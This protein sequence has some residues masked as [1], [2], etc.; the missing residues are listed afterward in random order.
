MKVTVKTG[1]L[2]RATAQS[3]AFDLF[4]AESVVVP[5]GAVR[6]V[7]TGVTTEMEGCYAVIKDRSGLA[8]RGLTTRAG[9]IDGDYRQEWGVVLVNESQSPYE[10]N[11]GDRIAQAL[12][13][14]LPAI[15]VV[16][17]GVEQS[18]AV[19]GGGFGSTGG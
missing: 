7:K 11:A 15:E 2:R 1:R 9:V 5:V 4:A 14:P 12:F 8:S 13:V 18:E 3:A 16:G 17:D 19:R 10:V 6:I